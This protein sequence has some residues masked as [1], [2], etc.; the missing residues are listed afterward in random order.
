MPVFETFVKSFHYIFNLISMKIKG[1]QKQ[2]KAK[3]K[4]MF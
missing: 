3:V 2:K 1:A 4:L